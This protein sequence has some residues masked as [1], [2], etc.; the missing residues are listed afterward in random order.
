MFTCPDI[1]TEPHHCI[2]VFGLEEI[3]RW[4]KGDLFFFILVVVM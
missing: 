4:W 1:I 2:A 3:P